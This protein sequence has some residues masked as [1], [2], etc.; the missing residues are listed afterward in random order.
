MALVQTGS[1]ITDIRGKVG[2]HVFQGNTHGL[3]LKNKSNPVN[4]L[5]TNQTLRR[6]A[7]STIQIAWQQLEP[8]QRT[9]WSQWA[10][11]QNLHHGF[12]KSRIL[13]GQHAFT[14]LNIYLRMLGE[15]IRT[16]PIFTPYS[17]NPALLS[18]A[19]P[20]GGLKL[21]FDHLPSDDY[22]W[23]IVK[24]SSLLPLARMSKPRDLKFCATQEIIYNHADI[25]FSYTNVFGVIPSAP[26]WIWVEW[27]II[28]KDNFT[29][30]NLVS[31]RVELQSPV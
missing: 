30:S 12:F 28:E 25:T 13:S 7:L 27:F 31:Q 8:I 1:V 15:P 14:Q 17:T 9:T 21:Y 16:T 6:S 26:G 10:V 22:I 4:K 2:G 11:Y 3:V 24:A 19:N 18:F 20:I 29:M 23:L 5:S